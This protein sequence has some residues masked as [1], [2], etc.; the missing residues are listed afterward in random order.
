MEKKLEKIIAVVVEVAAALLVLWLLGSLADLVLKVVAGTISAVVGFFS[1]LWEM[2]EFF[3]FCLVVFYVGRIVAGRGVGNWFFPKFED[4]KK[5]YHWHR[6][7]SGDHVRVSH[8]ALG[9]DGYYHTITTNRGGGDARDA[10]GARIH[11]HDHRFH[12]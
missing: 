1:G 8:R 9:D 12:R 11:Y 5:K 7:D 3:A 6:P 10:H 4:P 2:I